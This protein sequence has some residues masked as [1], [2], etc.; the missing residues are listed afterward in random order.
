MRAFIVG[1]AAGIWLL[2]SQSSLPEAAWLRG[3]ASI[4]VGVLLIAALVHRLYPAGTLAPVRMLCL[5]LIVAGGAAAGFAYSAAMAKSRLADVLP[6]AWEGVD[7]RIAGIISGLPAVNRSDRSVR[8]AFDVERVVA[9]ADAVVPSRISLSWFPAM[10][11]GRAAKGGAAPEPPMP[12]VHA[13]ERW[14]LVVRLRRPHGNANPHGFDIEAWMLENGLRASGYV[15]G[16]DNRRSDVFAGRFI[17]HVDSLRERIRERILRVLDGQPYAGV[18][19][20]LT[21]GDQ[22]SVSQDQW[23]LYN[24]TGVSHLLSI[25]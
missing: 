12:E 1:F 13:G 3:V 15:R 22:R 19:V 24:R 14:E 17:D 9:P 16:N 2:Q 10:R 6:P 11:A 5:P 8:F 4:A 20:A 25:R 7:V 18:L 23:A 21:I